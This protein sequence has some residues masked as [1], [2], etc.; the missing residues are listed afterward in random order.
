MELKDFRNGYTKVSRLGFGCWGIGKA[1]WVGADDAESK[2]AL[3]RAI[4]EGVTLFDTALVYGDGHSEQ[5]VGEV[6]RETE[7]ELFI[8]T[9]LP[10][11]KME[12]P[13]KDSST[14]RESFPKNYIIEMTEKSLRNLGRDHID[15]QQFHVWNDAWAKE[16]EWKE[17]I[18]KLRQDGKV[19]Y[20]GISINDHQP[21][22]G[23]EAGKSGFIDCFQV[24]FNIFDQ[25][26]ADE[27]LPF[28]EKEQISVLARVP[29]DEGGLTGAI[30]PQ[31]QFPEGDWRNYYFRDDRKQQAGECNSAGH[32]W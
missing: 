26:P 23:I 4:D 1:M 12:W 32:W 20:F 6:A 25:S 31:T 2:R 9:K 8:T 19:R 14:L 24:I 17:A 3:H 27:L 30:T 29:L 22:N 28:C 15:L 16:D 10:S 5:L 18:L 13:A 11:K 21:A 7:K